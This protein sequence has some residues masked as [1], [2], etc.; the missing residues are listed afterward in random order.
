MNPLFYILMFFIWGWGKKSKAWQILVDSISK[1]LVCEYT[2]FSV[3]FFFQIVFSRKWTLVSENRSEDKILDYTEVQKLIPV[4]TPKLNIWTRFSLL[5]AIVFLLFIFISAGLTGKLNGPKS[6]QTD[7][8]AILSNQND[9]R[10]Q[11]A[12]DQINKEIEIKQS[13]F[14]EYQTEF[15]KNKAQI[16]DQ[17]E[18]K[19]LTVDK[20]Y[21]IALQVKEKAKIQQDGFTKALKY[22]DD[23]YFVIIVKTVDNRE[24]IQTLGFSKSPFLV[25]LDGTN[26]K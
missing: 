10:V 18:Y 12:I 4:N 7:S 11:A 6:K 3:F 14:P 19:N 5:I 13:I 16:I 15:E 21:T 22:G 25:Y 2:Y 9:P 23:K 20:Y 1:Q 24:T 17:T 26:T 8:K